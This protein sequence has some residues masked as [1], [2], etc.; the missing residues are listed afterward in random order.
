MV[1]AL[2]M[3]YHALTVIRCILANQMRSFLTRQKEHKTGV[4][5]VVYGN[6]NES[7]TALCKYAG[8]QVYDLDW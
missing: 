8:L 7:S 1:K 3:K 5:N 6:I 4:T 2:S